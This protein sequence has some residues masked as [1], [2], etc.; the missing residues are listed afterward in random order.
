MKTK[1]HRGPLANCQIC[2]AKVAAQDPEYA[3]NFSKIAQA[4]AKLKQKRSKR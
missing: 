2:M 3:R 4:A 1:I